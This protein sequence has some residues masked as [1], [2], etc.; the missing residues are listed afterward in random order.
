MH[1]DKKDKSGNTPYDLAKKH[2][3]TGVIEYLDKPTRTYCKFY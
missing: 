3:H 2:G 1:P